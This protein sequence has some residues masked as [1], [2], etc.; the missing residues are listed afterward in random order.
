MRFGILT[1]ALITGGA[2]SCNN[3]N[4]VSDNNPHHVSGVDN[5]PPVIQAITFIPD[6]IIAG[7]S[8]LV[9]CTAID[10]ENDNLTYEWQ[11]IGNIAGSG[12]SIFFT[13][14]SCCSEPKIQLTITDGWGGEF[15][16]LFDVPFKY[17]KDE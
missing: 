6:T 5:T 12:A 7:Q 11:T 3:G 9:K 15:D 16:T 4:P 8:C 13:P 14:N 1:A 17:S 2:L 10:S